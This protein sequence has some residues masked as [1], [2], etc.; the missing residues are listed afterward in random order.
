MRS[1]DRK[2]LHFHTQPES[3]QLG[4]HKYTRCVG[5]FR[6][7][8]QEVLQVPQLAGRIPLAPLHYPE[9]VGRPLQLEAAVHLRPMA[10]PN[11]QS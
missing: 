5:T 7:L 9:A 4:T 11:Q 8:L 2:A 6:A 1:A 10:R 3:F